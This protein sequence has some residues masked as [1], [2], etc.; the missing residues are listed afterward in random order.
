MPWKECHPID[1]RLKFVAR[2]LDGEKMSPLCREFAANKPG[3]PQQNGHHVS[4][5][6]ETAGADDIE[7]ADFRSVLYVP[8][9]EWTFEGAAAIHTKAIP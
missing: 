9:M 1:E 2:L 7:T 6:I 3:N 5:G 8:R 4:S